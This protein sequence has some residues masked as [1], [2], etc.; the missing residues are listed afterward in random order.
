MLQGAKFDPTGA[1]VRR[2]VPELAALPAEFI[3]QPWAAP[4]DVLMSAAVTLGR[5]YPHPVVAHGKAREAALAAF[6]SMR[7]SRAG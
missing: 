1:Y 7:R 5:D 3:H 6:S 2:F 4:M